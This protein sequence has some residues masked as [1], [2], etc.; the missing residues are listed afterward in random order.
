MTEERM[1]DDELTSYYHSNNLR[2]QA[3]VYNEAKRARGGEVLWKAS[4]EN[5]L[6]RIEKLEKENEA[7]KKLYIGISS[8]D[9]DTIKE[10]EKENEEL[11]KLAN[12]GE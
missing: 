1:S 11:K 9:E 6:A 5:R 2:R 12:L 10:L 4:A 3:K 8:S 7:A